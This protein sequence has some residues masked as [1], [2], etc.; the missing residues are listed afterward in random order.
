MKFRTLSAAGI[1]LV[2]VGGCKSD[3]QPVAQRPPVVAPTPTPTPAPTPTP[4]PT[5]TPTP[6]PSSSD[7]MNPQNWQIGP[8]I[9]GTNY[10]VG[11]P[12]KPATHPEGW[13]IELPQPT[14][15]VGHVHYVTMPTG[16]LSGKTN[17]VMKYRIETDQGVRIVPKTAPE[18]PALLTL[19]FQRSGDDWSGQGAFEAYR[20][21]ASFTTHV[22]LKAG[23]YVM[24]ARF[25]QNWTAVQSSSATSNPAAFQAALS[26]AARIGFTLGGGDGLGHGVYATGPARL[27]V[28][29]FQVL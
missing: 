1:L 19:Y 17:I 4:S 2:T 9:N 27:I 29:D 10:S 11:M 23:D 15:T 26:N 16:S 25:D 22:D 8:I 20:W 6:T 28:T 7:P 13:V 3:A 24:T 5:P 14:S 12:L 21:W 18:L